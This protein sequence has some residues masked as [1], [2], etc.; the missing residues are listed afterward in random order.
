[1]DF[2]GIDNVAAMGGGIRKN[3]M[4]EKLSLTNHFTW[5][6]LIT[7]VFRSLGLLEVLTIGGESY[8]AMEER[9]MDLLVFNMTPELVVISTTCT[10][11]KQLWDKL[12]DQFAN[13][14]T[15]AK[16]NMKQ[17]LLGMKQGERELV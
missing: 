9:A 4:I 6:I 10:T 11:A 16:L 2:G 17:L 7:R 5:S 12:N 14:S 13:T 3:V 8:A 1:M 15:S